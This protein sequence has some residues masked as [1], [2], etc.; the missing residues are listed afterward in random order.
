MSENI[1]PDDLGGLFCS[2]VPRTFSPGR[3]GC[4]WT[5]VTS[6]NTSRGRKKSG[7]PWGRVSVLPWAY[8]R[9]A[10][11]NSQASPSTG[12]SSVWLTHGRWEAEGPRVPED[13][14]SGGSRA[15]GS[16]GW[17]QSLAETYCTAS[18]WICAPG[19]AS[20]VLSSQAQR[21]EPACSSQHAAIA[22]LGPLRKR[23][24]WN[25]TGLEQ[26]PCDLE[27]KPV[28]SAVNWRQ[29]QS[30]FKD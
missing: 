20:E 7:L 5:A 25:Q 10:D 3:E 28:S 22:F 29:S 14:V 9:G 4:M 19:L 30:C 23:G 17:S 18:A 6:P 26:I 24:L 16:A 12:H 2:E 8:F 13:D 27:Q 15:R 1:T 21:S 11:S